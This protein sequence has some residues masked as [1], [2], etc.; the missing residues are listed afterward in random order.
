V[1]IVGWI[2]GVSVGGEVEEESDGG[3]CDEEEDCDWSM[4][5]PRGGCDAV[6]EKTREA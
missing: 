1:R 3:G 2:A 6:G 5:L 4:E